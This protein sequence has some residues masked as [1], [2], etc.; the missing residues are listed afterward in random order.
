MSRRNDHAILSA[1]LLLAAALGAAC[2]GAGDPKQRALEQRARWNV[3][4]LDWSQSSEGAVTLST[5]LSGPPNSDLTQLTVRV[6]LFDQDETV[7]QSNWHTFDLA[8][9][10]RGGP[11]DKI[12]RIHDLEGEIAGAAIDLVL[13][14]G[15]D[16][17]PH[18]PELSP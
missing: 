14:P 8:D 16:D 4:L 2:V 10:E 7:V 3:T 17:E 13:Q 5:R 1:V 9:V 11:A 12:I 15:P 6:Q 18:I